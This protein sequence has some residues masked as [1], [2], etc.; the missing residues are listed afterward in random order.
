MDLKQFVNKIMMC[1]VAKLRKSFH[2]LKSDIAKTT[3]NLIQ[4][5]GKEDLSLDITKT[6]K[7]YI[8]SNGTIVG[9]K[10]WFEHDAILIS[11][12]DGNGKEFDDGY[13]FEELDLDLQLS[14]LDGIIEIYAKQP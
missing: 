14:I 9:D 5:Y 13:P 7:K 3:I 12:F 4:T 2:T 10:I 11:Y 1:D 6:G 8:A